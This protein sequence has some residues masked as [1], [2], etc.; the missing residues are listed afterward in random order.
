[1]QL[2]FNE[3]YYSTII[4]DA[5]VLMIE[6]HTFGSQ[7]ASQLTG[8]DPEISE[9]QLEFHHWYASGPIRARIFSSYKE[10]Q[11]KKSCTVKQTVNLIITK[12]S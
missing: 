10:N 4:R 11:F 5:T 2:N 3:I 8:S 12:Q 7:T 1:M 6:A 9:A